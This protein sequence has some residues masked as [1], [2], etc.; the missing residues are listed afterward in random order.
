MFVKSR[1][2]TSRPRRFF[3][4]SAL[5]GGLLLAAPQADAQFWFPFG[6]PEP[7]PQPQPQPARRHGQRHTRQ[8][9]AVQQQAAQPQQQQPLFWWDSQAQPAEQQAARPRVGRAPRPEEVLGERQTGPGGDAV[10]DLASHSG[11]DGGYDGGRSAAS[12]AV[13]PPDADPNYSTPV[14]LDPDVNYKYATRREV[15]DPTGE[16][17]GTI[18]ISTARRKLYYSLGDGRAMEYGVAVG[19]S[20]FSWKGQAIVGRKAYWPGWTPPKEMLARDPELPEHLDGSLSNPL[21]ARALY[22]FQD[23]KDTLFRIHG[24]NAPKSIGHAVSSGCIRME[25]ADVIDL[26]GR[27]GKGTRVVVR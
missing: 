20:G 27:V 1:S 19:K 18:T 13:L 7:Q 6:Q 17:A 4:H 8:H 22:L 2:C 24:T 5:L 26:Y 3:F 15:A 23:N 10:V 11:F 16:P 25:N 9:P 21:G 12:A 14:D